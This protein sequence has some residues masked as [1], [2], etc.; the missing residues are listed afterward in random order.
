MAVA[1][2]GLHWKIGLSLV[3]IFLAGAGL[4]W[5]AGRQAIYA[6]QKAMS[7]PEFWD[8]MVLGRME[9]R[10]GLT[11]EQRK[12]LE[13]LVRETAQKLQVQ[14]RRAVMEQMQT[15]KAFYGQVE[16][17]LTDEQRARME[18]YR[19]QLRDR[20]RE[21]MPLLPPRPGGFPGPGPGRG[22]VPVPP[23]P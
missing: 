17:H 19:Q 23:N 14:R 1:V 11:T 12:S 4:G 5:F 20:P 9:E 8:G 18:R 3:A 21:E 16:P 7:R 22:R 2:N 6:R 15:V 13:P 10:L